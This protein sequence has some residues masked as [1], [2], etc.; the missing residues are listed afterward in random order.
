MKAALSPPLPHAPDMTAVEEIE[1]KWDSG[2]R[3]PI[4]PQ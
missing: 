1:S 3:G 2:E 4:Y